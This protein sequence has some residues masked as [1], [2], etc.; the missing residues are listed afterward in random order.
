MRLRPSSRP[1]PTRGHAGSGRGWGWRASFPGLLDKFPDFVKNQKSPRF[2]QRRATALEDE[3]RS[4]SSSLS[5]VTEELRLLRP[6]ADEGD[7]S[8]SEVIRLERQRAELEGRY[9]NY[10]E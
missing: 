4:I 3:L 1:S 10:Q 7:V 8:E 9:R 6:L 2:A 5:S